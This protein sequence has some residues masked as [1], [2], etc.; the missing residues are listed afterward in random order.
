MA[1]TLRDLRKQANLTL[2]ETVDRL[3]E[4][5][6]AAPKTHVGLLHIER[7]GT[8]RLPIIRGLAQVFGLPFEVVAEAAANPLQEKSTDMVKIA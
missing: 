8:D 3:R 5:E 1:Q 6:P 2:E 4:V 7:R